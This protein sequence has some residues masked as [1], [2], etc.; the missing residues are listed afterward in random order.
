VRVLPP[1]PPEPR[2]RLL[3]VEV[4]RL[5]SYLGSYGAGRVL[6]TLTLLPGEKTKVSVKTYTHST[7]DAKQAS[8]ILDSFTKESADGLPATHSGVWRLAA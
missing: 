7:T 2:P 8:S 3:L 6:K 4:Y 5:S 1:V